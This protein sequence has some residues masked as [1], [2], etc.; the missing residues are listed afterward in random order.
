MNL[1]I[2]SLKRTIQNANYK[3]FEDQPN[4]I[5]IR[6]RLNVPDAFNDILCIVYKENDEEKLFTANITTDPGITYQLK[7]L[8]PKG[9][10]VMKRGQYL[11]AYKLGFHQNKPDHRALIQVGKITVF[12]DNDKDG[13]AETEGFPEE[14][15]YFGCNIHGA[16]KNV[17]T[18]KIGPWSAGCQ[19]HSRWS[20]KE[21][22]CDI[23]EKYKGVNNGLVTYTLVNEEMLVP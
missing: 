13:V 12:R 17:D 21:K 2:A 23:V 3:W 4:I 20:A 5:G 19:V 16:N 6:S 9:C 15:G 11:D 1:S 10:A 18:T 7:F 8:N 14:I 22:M